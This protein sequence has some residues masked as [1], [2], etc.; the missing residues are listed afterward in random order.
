MGK[1]NEYYQW[2]AASDA[3]LIAMGQ[4]MI[5][6]CLCLLSLNW[7]SSQP[8]WQIC[9][10]SEALGAGSLWRSS[11]NNSTIGV[12][13]YFTVIFA[14]TLEPSSLNNTNYIFHAEMTHQGSSHVWKKPCQHNIN[15]T[16]SESEMKVTADDAA[17]PMKPWLH[18]W[19]TVHIYIH[20]K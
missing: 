18:E 14:L 5:L 6:L 9:I 3:H 10:F 16:D 17:D 2:T 11:Q 8:C 12:C 1:L 15:D 13:Y 20:T 4:S 19:N 7:C